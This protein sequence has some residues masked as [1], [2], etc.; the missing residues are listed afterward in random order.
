MI[1]DTQVTG[2][3]RG[4]E[5]KNARLHDPIGSSSGSSRVSRPSPSRRTAA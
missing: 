4:G 2:M 3:H 1:D 5:E